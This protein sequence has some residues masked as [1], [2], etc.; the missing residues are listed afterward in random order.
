MVDFLL[1]DGFHSFICSLG[2]FSYC[3]TNKGRNLLGIFN[4]WFP[5]DFILHLQQNQHQSISNDGLEE[6]GSVDQIEDMRTKGN[7]CKSKK[8]CSVKFIEIHELNCLFFIYV[9]LFR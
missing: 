1:F 6:G 7:I 4:N 9:L 2:L 3:Q 5:I 8:D